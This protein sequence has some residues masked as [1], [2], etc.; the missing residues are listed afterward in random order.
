MLSELRIKNFAIIENLEISFQDGMNILSGETGAGKSIIIKAVNLLLGDRV[1]SD[2][3]R[4][5]EN[6]AVV[7]AL[8]IPA[9]NDRHI[10]QLKELGI[11]CEGELVLR[12]VISREGKNRVFI[13]GNL[14]TLSMLSQIAEGLISISSQHE[15]QTLL[16]PDRHLFLLDG[17]G[18][19][20]NQ[21]DVFNKFLTKYINVQKQ[22]DLAFAN[23]KEFLRKKEF[24]EFQLNEIDQVDIKP[25]EDV[26][27]LKE[28][29]ILANAEKLVGAASCGDQIIYSSEDSVVDRLDRVVAAAKECAPVD[30]VF[31]DLAAQL[32]DI[33]FRLEDL[34]AQFRSCGDRITVDPT[35]L[36]SI[37]GRLAEIEN[38]KKK[39]GPKVKDIFR[40][41]D[42]ISA[43]LDSLDEIDANKAELEKSLCMLRE[44]TLKL[45]RKLEKSR[46]EA[47]VRLSAEIEKEMAEVG[48][49]GSRFEVIF[50]PR[51]ERNGSKNGGMRE[52][53]LNNI[54]FYIS[55]NPGEQSKPVSKVASGGE[56]SRIMLALKSCLLGDDEVSSFVFDEVDAG[57]GGGIAEIVGKKIKKVAVSSQVI[58]ITHLPQ[59][60]SLGD[61][62]LRVSKKIE[63][64]RTYTT[65]EKLNKNKRIDEI[66]RMLAGVNITEKSRDHAMEMLGENA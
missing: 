34:S 20:E 5:G 54:E 38:L 7:E 12:R 13:N 2:V 45:G 21:R 39:Y 24:L 64:G 43:E 44:K 41:R 33:L 62:H 6:E 50:T 31:K 65:I 3:V 28:R 9:D 17:F 40:S 46:K 8:F 49:T 48:M 14:A 22:L 25:D 29:N 11:E 63:S 61:T 32:E 58:C 26:T 53:G 10:S 35:R 15:H 37:E 56:L 60:A 55:T 16:R 57:I 27:L 18:K 36:D 51:K 19:L 59:I 52:N 23:E 42:S 1:A 66:A 47:A 30:A 4:S